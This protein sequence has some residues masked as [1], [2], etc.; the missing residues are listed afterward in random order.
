MV[1]SQNIW[2]FL[3]PIQSV[4]IM[5]RRVWA[6]WFPMEPTVPEVPAKHDSLSAELVAT[7]F[8]AVAGPHSSTY[9]VPK[10]KFSWGLGCWPRAWVFVALPESWRSSLIW[11]GGDWPRPPCIV[12]RSTICSFGISRSPR[13]K[14]MNFGPSLKKTAKSLWSDNPKKPILLQ[15]GRVRSLGTTW[16]WRAFAPE[17]RLRL[18]SLV[19]NRN[20]YSA[21]RLL[22]NIQRCLGGSLPLI[23]SD[24]PKRA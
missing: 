19:G 6:A 14:W 17:F 20:L 1:R 9:E 2:T 21:H 24:T 22:R 8:P 7:P 11:S 16:F 4:N 12:S 5:E 10:R 18:A 3:V 23:T 15:K 13:S